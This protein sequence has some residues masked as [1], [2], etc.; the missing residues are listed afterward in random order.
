MDSKP[1]PFSKHCAPRG[2]GARPWVM[3]PMEPMGGPMGLAGGRAGGRRHICVGQLPIRSIFR[4][5]IV[6]YLLTTR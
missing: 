3:G 1:Y 6:T 5:Y 4:K 2:H